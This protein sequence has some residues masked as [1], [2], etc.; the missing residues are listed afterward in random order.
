MISLTFIEA[1]Y[2][3]LESLLR[4]RRRQKRNEDLRTELEY[5][6]EEYDK[7]REMELRPVCNMTTTLVLY[8][9]S[10]RTQRRIEMMV[11]FEN[12]PNRD[13]GRVER[14]SEG[15]RPLGWGEDNNINQGQSPNYPPYTQNG[16]PSLEG[17]SIKYP[18]GGYVLQALTSNNVPPYNGL[19]YPTIVG[20]ILNYK[21]LKAKFRSHFSQQKKFTNMHI[22]MYNIKQ[23]E[24]ESTRA[25]VTSEVG[26]A[27][28]SLKGNK[29]G[30]GKGLGHSIGR[31]YTTKRKSLEELTLGFREITFPFIAG[32]NNSFDP[33]SVKSLRVGSK[34][35]LV[36][37]SGEHSWPIREVPLEI[38]IGDSSFSKTKTHNFVIIRSNSP[39]NL[40]LGRTGMQ[41]MGIV[42]SMIHGAI[43]FHTPRGI[44]TVFL[45]YE[46]DKTGEGTKNLR[47]VPP[48]DIKGI[49]GCTD[50]KERIIVNS[51][52][53]IQM[54]KVDEDKTDFF[55]GEA[56]F[57]YRKIPFGLKNARETYQRLVKKLF[58][59]QI[60]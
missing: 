12:A 55:A 53:L 19:I 22:A 13:G 43:K 59:D 4:E 52:Y 40:L 1:N 18:Q 35:P 32:V 48:E 8:T 56:T 54:A 34:V 39:H 2:E 44:G 21:D 26:A 20:S 58:N 33:P 7:E 45:M 46:F 29:K 17:T 47:E 5:F 30:Q 57:Y 11:D 28:P 41:K 3:V 38:T 36:G 16:N 49:L 60:E 9:R 27:F 10:P 42:V 23:R 6:S 50:A 37:F 25:F 31:D 24:G 15:G 14:N 51:K